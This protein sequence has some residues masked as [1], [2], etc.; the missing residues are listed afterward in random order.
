MKNKFLILTIL[1]V[2]FSLT[3]C[4]ERTSVNQSEPTSSNAVS[5]ASPS[6]PTNSPAGKEMRIE[7]ENKDS[8]KMIVVSILSATDFYKQAKQRYEA[9]HPNTKI[10]FKEFVKAGSGSGVMSAS[11]VEKYIKQSTTEILSGKGADLFAL[12]TVDLPIDRYVNKQ[13][14]VNVGEFIKHDTSFDQSQYYMNILDNSKMN[15]GLYVLPT[16]FYLQAMFGDQVAIEK[17]GVAIDDKKWTWSQFA[18]VSK[19]LAAKG[20]HTHSLSG[21]D[22]ENMLNAIVSD[23][24][25]RFVDGAKGKSNFD[26]TDFTDLLKRVKSL[27]DDKIISA[28]PLGAK[29]SNFLLSEFFSPSDFITRNSLYYTSGTIYQKPHSAE[30]QS[31]VAFGGLQSIAMNANSTIKATAW[32]FMKFLLSE[33]MQSIP[34]QTGFPLKKSVNERLIDQISNDA[35][36]GTV[37]TMKGGNVKVSEKDIQVLKTMISEASLPISKSDKVRS[38]IAEESKA[39]FTGQKTAEAVAKLIQNRVMTYLNE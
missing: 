19:S 24:Y 1:V 28:K 27:Y 21:L 32:D 29:D 10:E 5:T 8:K 39:F 36:K 6:S 11:E 26:S 30:Q 31:G 37:S 17:A 18:D 4:N 2:M 13:A 9:A 23:N 3:A 15:G 22:P 20:A 35:K 33:E 16:M 25:E 12:T 38:I 34:Q 7:D 14:F